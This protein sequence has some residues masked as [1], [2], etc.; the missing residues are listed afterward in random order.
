M[1]ERQ[2]HDRLRP[3]GNNYA[4]K[5]ATTLI[6]SPPPRAGKQDHEPHKLRYSKLNQ[7]DSNSRRS[8][9]SRS[10]RKRAR[11]RRPSVDATSMASIESEVQTSNTSMSEG[12]QQPSSNDGSLDEDKLSS[13]E[14][15]GP[16]DHVDDNPTTPDLSAQPT[17]S[18]LL[19]N[20]GR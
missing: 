11:S 20:E 14:R 3:N 2:E 9:S 15:F 8:K 13:A 17:T 1:V 5:G 12:H 7:L 19:S 6:E 18:V 16:R 10:R 4:K